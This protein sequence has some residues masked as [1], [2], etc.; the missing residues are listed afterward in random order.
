MDNSPIIEKLFRD[1]DKLI[2]KIRA[3]EDALEKRR[4]AV[5]LLRERNFQLRKKLAA[6]QKEK[7][8]E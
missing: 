7:A 4:R 1:R 5:Y 2:D 6:V 8:G 3:L